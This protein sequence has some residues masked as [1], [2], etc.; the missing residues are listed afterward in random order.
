[1]ITSA[2]QR[3]QPQL[4]ATQ[5]IYGM[6]EKTKGGQNNHQ[7]YKSDICKFVTDECCPVDGKLFNH[8]S[9]LAT[10]PKYKSL[11]NW[12]TKLNMKDNKLPDLF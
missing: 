4:A 10:E 3:V 12:R 7:I 5:K 9:E 2:L 6:V 1:M 8:E 11:R